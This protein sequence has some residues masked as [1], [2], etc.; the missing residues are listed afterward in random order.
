MIAPNPIGGPVSATLEGL[1]REEVRRLG[2]VF[3]LDKEASYT[4]FIDRLTAA[5]GPYPVC[6]YRGSFL[7]LMLDLE[8]HGS[9]VDKEPLLVHLPGF[10]EEDV[11]ASPLL[12]L[13]AA[14]HRYRKALD[15]LVT[16][17][18]AGRVRPEQ[19]ASFQGQSSLTLEGA[20]TWLATHM[21]SVGDGLTAQLTAMSIE[22][23]VDDLLGS[24]FIAGRLQSGDDVE[25]VWQHCARA[26]GLDEAWRDDSVGQSAPRAKDVAYSIASWALVVEY[27]HDLARPPL[28][29]QLTAAARLPGPVVAVCGALAEHLRVRHPAFYQA[30]ST[31]TETRIDEE[32]RMVQAA[33]LGKIDTF[34]FE[35]RA[36]L[37][38]AVTALEKGEWQMALGWATPRAAAQS[39]WTRHDPLRQN[40]WQLVLDIANVGAAIDAAGTL[41][42]KGAK[43]TSLDAATERYVQAGA[44][45]DRAHRVMEQRRVALLYPQV[46]SFEGLRLRLDEMRSRWRT[47]ADGWAREWN[48]VCKNHGFLPSAELQQRHLFD[49]VV[50]HLAVDTASSTET[51]AYFVVDALR[52]EMAVELSDA[53]GTI[54][55]TQKLLKARLAELP[56]VT[57]VGMNVLAPVVDNGRLKPVLQGDAIKGFTAGEYRVFNPETRRRAM[58]DRVGGKGCPRLTLEEVLTRETASLKKTVEQARL[59]VVH[60]QEIDNAGEKGVGAS[61]FDRVL[62]DLRAAWR[63]LREAGVRR[64]V[65]T[66][67]HG[68]LILDDRMGDAKVHGSKI[69]PK[70]RHVF[71]ESAAD[72]S[73]EVRVALKD[74]GYD[75]VTGHLMFPETVAVFDT[76]GR[77]QNFVH[78]GNSPQERVIPVLTLV[79]KQPAGSDTHAYLV[80]ATAADGV[81][82]MHC[83]QASVSVAQDSLFGGKKSIELGLRTV[84]GPDTV[85]VELGQARGGARLNGSVI[86]ADVG[87]S[88]EVFF[89]LL[90]PTDDRLRVELCHTGGDATVQ[91]AVVDSRFAVTPITVAIGSRPVGPGEAAAAG[92][93]SPA[94]TVRSS[95]AWLADFPDA[96]VRQVFEHVS[97]HGTITETEATGMLGGPRELRKFARE[98]ETHAARVPF[99]VRIDIVGGIKR[100]I[101]EGSDG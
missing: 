9:R 41:Q 57:E 13:Y 10:V 72:H 98:F 27:V 19:I 93:A 69:V 67:D 3:F 18:A 91:G 96:R 49:G 36:I 26:I 23:I 38:A 42:V 20:D 61:V 75:G 6:A 31:E 65:I 5:G 77:G 17:A 97:L 94:V 101:R 86:L 11:K 32:M 85:I 55:G 52:Y 56:S 79:H 54:P 37:A 90:G 4:A 12:E 88:F 89:R 28:E 62:Q 46:P 16:D 51:T 25:L 76:G 63:L 47:W 30:T 1:L 24:G 87:A 81:A 14:G 82:G 100:Y 58:F 53:L 15:T 74:L 50:K 29:Q 39:F 2:M 64:F 84:D 40:A 78:G 80:T 33:D 7:Q 48:A 43:V 99:R 34:L 21:L 71:S 92:P 66:S 35:E 8:A 59:L 73:G 45:V 68:F 60:S 95:S 22:A 70:R 83:L 44:P